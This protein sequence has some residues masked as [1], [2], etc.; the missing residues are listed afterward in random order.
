MP[1]RPIHALAN[2]N[3]SFLF[4]GWVIRNVNLNCPKATQ[5]LPGAD[6]AQS[7]ILIFSKFLNSEKSYHMFRLSSF[8]HEH[9][10]LQFSSLKLFSYNHLFKYEVLKNTWI[11]N[12]FLKF[13]IYCLWFPALLVNIFVFISNLITLLLYAYY[14]VWY[15]FYCLEFVEACFTP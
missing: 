1:S 13:S 10:K 3:I 7:N 2:G 11:L 12:M 4:Y 6:Y 8:S 5:H 15:D 14:M 9:L